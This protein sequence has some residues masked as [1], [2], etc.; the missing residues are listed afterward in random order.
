MKLISF[1]Q[2]TP[3]VQFL[4]SW[5]NFII[6]QIDNHLKQIVDFIFLLFFLYFFSWLTKQKKMNFFFPL[7][8]PWITKQVK[9]F[10]FISLAFSFLPFFL[11]IFFLLHFPIT[12]H[13]LKKQP[14]TF[15][16]TWMSWNLVQKNVKGA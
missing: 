13:S 2:S 14:N 11:P 10:M 4:F 16:I 6:Q 7:N 5:K 1:Y 8:F 12:K 9:K 3:R 15:N